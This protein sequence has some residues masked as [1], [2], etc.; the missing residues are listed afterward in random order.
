[1]NSYLTPG[2]ANITVAD[3]ADGLLLPAPIHSIGTKTRSIQNRS[4]LP[5]LRQS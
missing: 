5:W 4:K 1:M 3:T 2:H